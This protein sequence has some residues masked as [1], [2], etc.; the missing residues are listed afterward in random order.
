MF[1]RLIK[2]FSDYNMLHDIID[3]L[4]ASLEV[5]DHYTSGHSNRVCD[6]IDAMTSNRAYRQA[7]TWAECKAE[8]MAN[9]GTQFDPEVVEAIT[10]SLWDKWQ[11][12]YG[13]ERERECD[14]G[15]GVQSA[16]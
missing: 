4:T 3:C 8:I 11:M 10:D 9:K 14:L 12:E 7:F 5:K 15:Q 13:K 2:R 16:I 1:Y 6:S